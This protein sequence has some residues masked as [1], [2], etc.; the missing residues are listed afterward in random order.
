MST[1][2]FEIYNNSI[3]LTGKANGQDIDFI[4]DTGDAIGPVF[5]SEDSDRLHL[6][7]IQA[8]TVSGAGGESPIDSCRATVQLGDDIFENEPSAIDPS[9]QG[10][11]LIG[12]PFFL[13]N[14]SSITLDFDN[15]ELILKR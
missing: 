14:C 9:L 11:S 1:V 8:E 13:N 12:L 5:N 3:L 6:V 7:P 15:G 2:S 4:L 10:P